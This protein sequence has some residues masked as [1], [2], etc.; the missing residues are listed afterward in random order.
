MEPTI[1]LR[2]SLFKR[3]GRQ[4]KQ[5][6]LKQPKTVEVKVLVPYWILTVV[7]SVIAG[8]IVGYFASI[9]LHGNAR[10]NVLRDVTAVTSVASKK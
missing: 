6:T 4:M 9:D 8:L 7:M 10:A 2:A 5:P 1:K 3:K